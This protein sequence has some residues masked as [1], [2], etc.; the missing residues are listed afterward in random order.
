MTQAKAVDVFA[1]SGCRHLFKRKSFI[2]ALFLIVAF[3]LLLDLEHPTSYEVT[4]L[5]VT[6]HAAICSS[7]RTT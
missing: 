7:V 6:R 4:A 2:L 3:D 1:A 5:F